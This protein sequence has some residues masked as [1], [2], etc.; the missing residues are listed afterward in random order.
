MSNL[1]KA[2]LAYYGIGI[3]ALGIALFGLSFVV[4]NIKVPRSGLSM[5]RARLLAVQSC[6][7]SG[8]LGALLILV[9]RHM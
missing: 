1:V 5:A 2:E 8:M 4:Y 3:I 6:I 9:R 7:A